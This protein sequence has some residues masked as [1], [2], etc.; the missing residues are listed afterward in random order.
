MP[1]PT[2][3]FQDTDILMLFIPYL[4]CTEDPD[5]TANQAMGIGDMRPAAWFEPFGNVDARD[6]KRGFRR[7]PRG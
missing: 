1:A 3:L 5:D 4:D 6:P 2:S 7:S